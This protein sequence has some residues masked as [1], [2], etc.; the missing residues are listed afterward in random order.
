MSN[1]VDYKMMNEGK[2]RESD[3]LQLHD[4]ECVVVIVVV[5]ILKITLKLQVKIAQH[6]DNHPV[7]ISEYLR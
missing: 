3:V 2:W 1:N 5:M 4:D 6:D 7:L